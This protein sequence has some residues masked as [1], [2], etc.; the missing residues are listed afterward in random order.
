MKKLLKF[1]KEHDE[2]EVSIALR[3]SAICSMTQA[4]DRYA[5]KEA[6]LNVR[7]KYMILHVVQSLELLLK[8][9]LAKNN[10]YL[11][12]RNL[13]R[14]QEV[15]VNI[16]ESMGR[17]KT[18]LDISIDPDD[19]DSITSIVNIRNHFEHFVYTDVDGECERDA[20]CVISFWWG[21]VKRY[22]PEINVTELLEPQWFETLEEI[23]ENHKH[24]LEA[25]IA[26]AKRR[27][28]ELETQGLEADI[29]KC[30][31]CAQKCMLADYSARH[32]HCY[33]CDQEYE[34]R[35]CPRC[36][37][38]YIVDTVQDVLGL[39]EACAYGFKKTMDD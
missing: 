31:Y 29:V 19:R 23:T 7:S 26:N 36:G 13:D 11:I 10:R 37:E 4:L 38:D 28:K 39:C 20:A 32:A 8:S 35:E 34:I 27:L 22:V 6:P 9:I 14:Q 12:L 24:F 2:Q 5:R 30:D 18:L 15:T 17:L 16:K 21:F 33:F 3:E 25:C 1:L